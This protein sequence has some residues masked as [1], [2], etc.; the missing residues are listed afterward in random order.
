[1]LLAREAEIARK[2][3]GD[4]DLRQV[5]PLRRIAREYRFVMRSPDS[6]ESQ[7][8]GPSQ[9][10]P[11]PMFGNSEFPTST[12]QLNSAGKESL[13]KA[14]KIVKAHPEAK[15]QPSMCNW[16][17]RLGSDLW[18]SRE[19]LKLYKESLECDE[20]RRRTCT[21]VWTLRCSSLRGS[22]RDITPP[23]PAA[24]MTMIIVLWKWN[25]P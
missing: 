5:E 12:P 23:L 6:T 1:V 13:E 2:V 18:G 3:G 16:I 24:A 20:R 4:N 25:S 7:N 19:A 10:K 9:Q 21:A 22:S 17:W 8:D 14:L 11:L 15:Q